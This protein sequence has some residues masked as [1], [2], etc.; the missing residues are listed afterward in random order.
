M[1][2]DEVVHLTRVYH[3]HRHLVT[4]ICYYSWSK[5]AITATDRASMIYCISNRHHELFVW[6]LHVVN[7]LQIH[8]RIR[9]EQSLGRRNFCGILSTCQYVLFWRD[10]LW[11]C[12]PLGNREWR[13]VLGTDLVHCRRLRLFFDKAGVYIRLVI[14]LKSLRILFALWLVGTIL[15]LL[16][17]RF[18][19]NQII[20][21]VSILVRRSD[22]FM[23]LMGGDR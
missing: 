20:R 8:F 6:I 14:N 15:G 19:C 9:P 21:L 12:I 2:V 13:G 16:C 22:K 7:W 5:V 10:V 18:R 4:L 3:N 1:S 17:L 23:S 11:H